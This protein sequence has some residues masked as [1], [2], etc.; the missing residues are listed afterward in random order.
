[1]IYCFKKYQ[2]KKLSLLLFIMFSIYIT[3]GAQPQIDDLTQ[4]ARDTTQLKD[5]LSSIQHESEL[6]SEYNPSFENT[7]NDKPNFVRDHWYWLLGLGI[8]LLLGFILGKSMKARAFIPKERN[9]NDLDANQNSAV[10]VELQLNQTL[11]YNRMKEFDQ[12]YFDH[13]S[14]KIIDP[15]WQSIEQQDKKL[16]IEHALKGMAHFSSLTRYKRGVD[17]KFDI[18]NLH[19]LTEKANWKASDAKAI[20]EATYQDDIPNQIQQIIAILKNAESKGLDETSFFG[21]T[22]KQI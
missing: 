17:Q 10:N 11:L 4:T 6:I 7:I 22:I 16:I 3:I 14:R 21:Y 9:E 1:M 19:Y 20:N 13:A 12:L 18:Y 2:M 8:A 5:T 15:F